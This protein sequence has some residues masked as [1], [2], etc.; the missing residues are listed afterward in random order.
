[1]ATYWSVFV[2]VRIAQTDI[3]EIGMSSE[4]RTT[5]THAVIFLVRGVRGPVL[6]FPADTEALATG[7]SDELLESLTFTLDVLPYRSPRHLEQVR[8][9]SD[10]V[11]PRAWKGQAACRGGCTW[12][13]AERLRA[14]SC[15]L[16][17][18][19]MISSRK[20]KCRFISWSRLEQGA[21]ARDRTLTEEG[22]C[23]TEATSA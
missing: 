4:T 16:Q 18:V 6:D 19:G 14:S 3:T 23:R 12:S 13:S 5:S 10:G 20:T 11:R 22:R 1:V 17:L 7:P 8:I 15:P 9:E 21:V 2:T